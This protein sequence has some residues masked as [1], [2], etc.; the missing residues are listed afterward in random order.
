MTI[1]QLT[2]F[3][4]VLAPIRN[5]AY[6]TIIL[7]FDPNLCAPHQSR[8]R[9]RYVLL[10][11]VLRAVIRA[12]STSISLSFRVVVSGL[13]RI[14]GIL[15]APRISFPFASFHGHLLVLTPFTHFLFQ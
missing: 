15:I 2:Q 13:R 14:V 3:T 5:L 12:C 10:F 7:S 11:L 1:T 6:T 4:R 8:Q 9:R